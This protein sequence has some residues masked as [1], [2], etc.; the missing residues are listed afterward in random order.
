MSGISSREFDELRCSMREIICPQR[1]EVIRKEFGPEVVQVPFDKSK[2]QSVA[3]ICV[4]IP[5]DLR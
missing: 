2:G 1:S 3:D 4:E 5:E